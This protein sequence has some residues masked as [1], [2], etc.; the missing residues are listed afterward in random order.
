MPITL[1]EAQKRIIDECCENM[2]KNLI[3]DLM[4]DGMCFARVSENGIEIVDP[5]DV[6]KSDE[7]LDN[8]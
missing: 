4:G 3:D 6:F 8:A 7:D 1:R 2:R 5:K